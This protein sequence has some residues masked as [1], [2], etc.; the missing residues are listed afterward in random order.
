MNT[1]HVDTFLFGTPQYLVHSVT[2]IPDF[3]FLLNLYKQPGKPSYLAVHPKQSTF[4]LPKQFLPD[5]Y[6]SRLRY[7]MENMEHIFVDSTAYPAV[8]KWIWWLCK[9]VSYCHWRES[10]GGCVACQG[11]EEGFS[12]FSMVL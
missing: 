11:N 2:L 4:F 5:S 9:I 7:G 10:T 3:Y 1:S 6:C 12:T 8:Q